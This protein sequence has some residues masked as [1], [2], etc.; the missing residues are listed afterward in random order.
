MINSVIADIEDKMKKS[1]N[2]LEH[3]FATIR[4]GRANPAMFD[5][6]I[7]E[8]YG[9]PMPLS[10]VASITCPEP[11]LVVIQPWDKGTL[12]SIEKAILKS[13]LSLNPNNDGNLIRLQIPELT[14]ETRKDYVKQAKTKAEECRISI[15]NIRRDGNDKIKRMGK[16]KEVSEDD[17]KQSEDRVQKLTDKYIELIQKISDNKEKEILSI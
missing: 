5:G 16:D 13:S 3:D 6:I 15:R 9:S 1:I 17:V 4:T 11:R 14:E 8:A 10:Q 12:S 2:K 7:V